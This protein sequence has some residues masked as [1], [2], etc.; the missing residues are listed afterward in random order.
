MKLQQSVEQANAAEMPAPP[1]G[2]VAPHVVGAKKRKR[3]ILVGLMLSM[4]AAWLSYWYVFQRFVETTDNAY[5]QADSVAIAPKVSGYI[6]EVFVGDNQVV[7]VGQPL[8]R[9]DGRSYKAALEQAAATVAARRA[10]VAQVEANLLQ[11]QSSIAQAR[12]QLDG[13]KQAAS[14]AA[15]KLERYEP[16]I[17]QGGETADRLAEVRNA[18]HQAIATVAADSA[19]LQVAER[20]IAG[21]HAQLDQ[22]WAQ[23][24][25]A[26]A[27]ARQS[28]ADLDDTVVRSTL[29]GHVGDRT[30]RAGQFVQPGTRMMTVVPM[31]DIYLV[32]NFKETQVGAMRVGQPVTISIDALPG[33]QL[34]GILDSFAPGTGAQFSL[35]P[36]ENATGNF[37][38]I[39]QRIPVRIQ[40]TTN[41]DE[42]KALLP[43]MS[44][45]VR[46]DTQ[47]QERQRRTKEAYHG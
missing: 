41:E 42:R 35:L 30:V 11:H 7:S 20:Q 45:T 36:A 25:A 22:A 47:S 33:K 6:A 19:A 10:D 24:R 37:T 32:A 9:L 16:L 3:L 12:A 34:H 31:Q 46:I 2:D 5:L 18:S 29:A 21:S 15:T 23:L 27:S 44:A 28:Q 8:V 14:Y 38:K 26:E 13:A 1:V 4:G 40:L 39:V 43:G 17:A